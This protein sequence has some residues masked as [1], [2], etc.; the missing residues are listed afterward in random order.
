[1]Q[2]QRQQQRPLPLLPCESCFNR[3]LFAFTSWVVFS[4]KKRQRAEPIPKNAFPHV[5]EKACNFSMG[6][7]RTSYRPTSQGLVPETEARELYHM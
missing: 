6:F 2:L 1:M 5:I 3:I 4:V 7:L